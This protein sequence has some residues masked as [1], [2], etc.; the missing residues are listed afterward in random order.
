MNRLIISSNTLPKIFLKNNYS[1][2][3]LFESTLYLLGLDPDRSWFWAFPQIEGVPPCARGGHSATLIGASIL[4]FGGHYYGG[5]KQGYVYL[6]DTHVL[7]LNSSRWIKPKVQGT[8]PQA[9]FGHTALLAGSRIIIF[10][11]KG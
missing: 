9:R 11:G 2:S 8:P 1:V 3:F 4:F 6:N 7:D 5:Q 10:G